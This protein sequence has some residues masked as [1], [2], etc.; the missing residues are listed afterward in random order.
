MSSY[1]LALDQG[2]TSSRAI[3][4]DRNGLPVEMAQNE[5][6]QYFPQ[7]G[8]V[9][10]DPEEI[11]Q[12]QL[13]AACEVIQKR[14]ISADEIAAL[15]I[16]NQRETAVLWDRNTGQPVSR[17]IVW[18]CRRTAALCDRLR[19][20]GYEDMIRSRTGLV[21]DAY[22]SGTKIQWILDNNPDL[23]RRAEKGELAFGTVDSW[24][25]YRLTGGRL[26]VTDPTNASRT[27]LYNIAERQWDREIYETF[28]IPSSLLPE[29]VSS[30]GV[31]GE[32]KADLFGRAIP[33]AGIAG[34]QQAALF[35]Q[36][37]FTPGEVKNTYGTGCFLLMQT[38][39]NPAASSGGLLSTVAWGMGDQ[40]AYALEGSIFTA[41]AVVQWLRDQ[42]GIITHAADS[43]AAAQSV[44]DTGGMYL[45]PAFTGLGAP[46]W[47]MYARGLM[48]GIT[49]GTTRAHIIRAALES[50]AYQTRDVVDMMTADAGLDM[51]R[52]RVDGGA[53]AN[54][55]LMQFQADMLGVPVV[56]PAV[57]E[58]TA[59]GAAFLAGLGV[60]FW[61][62]RNALPVDQSVREFTPNMDRETRDRLYNGWRKAV[63]RSRDWTE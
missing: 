52:L 49:R 63:D 8:W 23:R 6:P 29:V 40:M 10:H 43:E 16:T 61:K 1:I 4:F 17:A 48:I 58:S 25:I 62:D 60:G 32:T 39:D 27:M 53:A 5:F 31:V 24:L 47:D 33:I 44:E 28:H 57:A 30:S 2:T 21:L 54:D 59:R 15:G 50:I 45:V 55:F 13:N 41:G 42:L 36:G 9:E 22:F 18:Q 51:Q 20:E 37:C 19:S 34:D 56:R 38:G 7:P 12:S 11:W 46:H 35:G 26:H 3:L 14:G